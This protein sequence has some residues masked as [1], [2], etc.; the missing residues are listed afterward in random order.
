MVRYSLLPGSDERT[1]TISTTDKTDTTWP[2]CVLHRIINDRVLVA[3][4]GTVGIRSK[5]P[6]TASNAA[7]TIRHLGLVSSKTRQL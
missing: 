5:Y 1:P 6:A 7:A 2:R 4:H 3:T